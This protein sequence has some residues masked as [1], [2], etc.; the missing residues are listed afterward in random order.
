LSLA[1]S[2]A[3]LVRRLGDAFQRTLRGALLGAAEIG[4]RHDTDEA[5]VPIEYRKA[6]H[7]MLCH[8]VRGIFRVIV[9]E[10]VAD[11]SDM[12]S[13]TVVLPADRSSATARTTISRSVTMPMRRS[14]SPTGNAP[15]LSARMRRATSRIVMFG[16]A[17]WTVGVMI[18]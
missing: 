8:D 7:L 15:M 1:A 5:L 3:L 4:E 16:S 10:A 12:T 2:A 13:R 14:F 17:M 11:A 6:P 18:S 9:L